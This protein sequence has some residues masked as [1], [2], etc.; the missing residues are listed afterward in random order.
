LTS[1]V[2]PLM[3]DS[4][5]E[6]NKDC[7]KSATVPRAESLR[8]VSLIVNSCP[9]M[10]HLVAGMVHTASMR[11]YCRATSLSMGK[12]PW[13]AVSR[14]GGGCALL[15][16]AAPNSWRAQPLEFG[17]LRSN[18]SALTVFEVSQANLSLLCVPAP[19]SW[20]NARFRGRHSKAGDT[21][22]AEN[23]TD[24]VTRDP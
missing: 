20:T 8:G 11:V 6:W 5:A 4:T 18:L 10:P 15:C 3:G 13:G 19:T 17:E 14:T 1:W 22:R 2:A 23:I 7:P 12:S 24:H 16:T 21:Y 9:T